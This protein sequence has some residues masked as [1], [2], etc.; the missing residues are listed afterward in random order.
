MMSCKGVQELLLTNYID[1]DMV[2]SERKII[3]DHLKSCQKCK[4]FAL[5][6]KKVG[7]DSFSD[8]ERVLPS[9]SVWRRV[10]MQ[11]ASDSKRWDSFKN[12]FSLERIKN[13]FVLTR[14]RLALASILLVVLSVTFFVKISEQNLALNQEEQIAV[15][16]AVLSEDDSFF[17]EELGTG[18]EEYFL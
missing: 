1:G 7:S 12:I 8:I 15:Y 4:E 14:P 10:R 13:A 6:A 5:L 17:D 9:E 11:V 16:L 2:D 18:I 3:D